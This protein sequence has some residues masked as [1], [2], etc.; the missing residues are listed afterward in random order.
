LSG[1]LPT[2]DRLED[3]PQGV[4]ERIRA[5]IADG[6]DLEDPGHYLSRSEA[7]FGVLCE[8]VRTGCSDDLMA[9][10][11]LDPRFKISAHILDKPKRNRKKYA[12][13]QV[14]RARECVEGAFVMTEGNNPKPKKRSQINIRLAL[15]KMGVRVRFNKFT[16]E[17]ILGGL[18]EYGPNLDDAALDHLWLRAEALFQVPAVDQDFFRRVV[19]DLARE[20]AFDP[21]LDYLDNLEWDGKARLD[22]FLIRLG[23]AEDTPFTRA[24]TSIPLIAAVRRS[25]YP[26]AKFDEMLVLEGPQ[27]CGKSS[28]IRT[29]SVRDE[30]YLDNLPMNADAKLII[31]STSGKLILEVAELSGMRKADV[32][33]VKSM[34][35]RTSDRARPAY[36]RL[37]IERPRRFIMIGSTNSS[38]Y[39]RDT[40]GNR[41]FW[42]VHV[43]KIDTGSLRGELD[44]LW[45]EAAQREAQGESIRLPEGLWKDAHAAQEARR[46]EDPIFEVLEAALGRSESGKIRAADVWRILEKR[47]GCATQADNV[48]VGDAMKRLGFERKKARFGAQPEYGYF[49]GDGP[50]PR[51]KLRLGEFGELQG[52][53]IEE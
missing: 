9:A 42:P 26:G 4:S 20:D 8:L 37:P 30:W 32:E 49:R 39:L 33:G 43:K 17:Y 25:R 52:V 38:N 35:S 46:S 27:G 29:L 2:L 5:L 50:C 36:G 6:E 53:E 28:A 7:V 19:L 23:G 11:I 47:H 18:P 40:S 14:Q 24:V 44:Q 45:A 16:E 31:E 22:D 3:L 41:R 13:R 51:Y 12:E 21:L 15:S 34:L 10:I 1:N 48:R